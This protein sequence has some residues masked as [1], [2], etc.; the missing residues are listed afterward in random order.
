LNARGA[1]WARP[2]GP[3]APALQLAGALVSKNMAVT[4]NQPIQPAHPLPALLRLLFIAVS[5]RFFP[6]VARPI[7]WL[8]YSSF[9]AGVD[10]ASN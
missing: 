9:S 1:A 8:G 2:L 10:I 6:G 5:F 3:F 7:R 4:A